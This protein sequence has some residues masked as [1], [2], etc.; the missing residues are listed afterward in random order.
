MEKKDFYGT[1]RV[2]AWPE[3][4]ESDGQEGYAVTYEDGYTSWSPKGVFE[5]AY[6][7]IDALSFGHAIVVLKSGGKVSRKGWNGVGL[8]LELQ[9]PDEHSKMTLPYIYLNYPDGQRV[10][11]LASQ[12]DVLSDDWIIVA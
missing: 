9:V 6:Q 7:P 8:W 3:V 12:T 1:K 4:R 11:W 5:A 10:P 2:T